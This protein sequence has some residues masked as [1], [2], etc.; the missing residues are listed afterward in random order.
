MASEMNKFLYSKIYQGG[1]GRDY[2]SSID[3]LLSN[4]MVLES[5]KVSK[6]E[7][8]L[9]AFAEQDKFKLY[10]SD[11]GIL[12]NMAGLDFVDIL[13]E[14]ISQF[15]GAIAENFVAMELESLE[16]PL[17]YW[18]SEGTAEVDFLLQTKDGVIPIEVKSG[19]KTK[20]KSLAV[21][22]KKYN[23]KYALR[24]SAKNFGYKNK[25]NSVPL[26]ATFCLP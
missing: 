7:K 4:N 25:I 19:T 8:P 3:W 24:I 22:M 15:K 26:Y 14:D 16:K 18:E 5:T 23:P 2:I 1:R 9:I 17:Y 21:Y 10:L 13:N 20:S 12:A 6:A 11:V